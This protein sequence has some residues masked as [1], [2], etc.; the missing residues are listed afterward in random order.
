MRRPIA[1]GWRHA[2]RTELETA[3]VP[4]THRAVAIRA[5]ELATRP[6]NGAATA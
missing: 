4:L 2:A 5:A 1:D 3:G 6:A